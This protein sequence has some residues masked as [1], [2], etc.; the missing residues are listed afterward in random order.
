MMSAAAAK[1]PLANPV[2]ILMAAA[3]CVLLIACAN[4]ASLLLARAVARKKEMAVR[5]AL[6]AGRGRLVR[7]MV[8]E[9]TMLAVAGGTLGLLF[10]QAGMMILARLVPTGLPNS[11]KPALDPIGPDL[12]AL[13]CYRA[14]DHTPPGDWT[15]A[16][17]RDSAGRAN[18]AEIGCWLARRIP[19]E[20]MN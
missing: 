18:G 19:Y 2:P 11:A 6:G 20:R 14:L 5:A 13:P 7:Q 1:M 4:L 15:L 17:R 3:G 8:T 16:F 12:W 10:A 9:A